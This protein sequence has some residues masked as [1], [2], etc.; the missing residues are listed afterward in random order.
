MDKE[1]TETEIQSLK[2]QDQLAEYEH[3]VANLRVVC[4]RVIAQIDE[5]IRQWNNSRNTLKVSSIEWYIADLYVETLE[6]QK[7][8]LEDVILDS[9]FKLATVKYTI[10]SINAIYNELNTR[11]TRK[12]VQAT[13]QS[14]LDKSFSDLLQRLEKTIPKEKPFKAKPPDPRQFM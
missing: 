11:V 3:T 6:N 8:F 10:D 2:E 13:I 7:R 1:S 4:G 14:K 5:E 9:E 12:Q